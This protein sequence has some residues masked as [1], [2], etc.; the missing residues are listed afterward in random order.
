M[1]KPRQGRHI[2]KMSPL[3][4]ELEDFYARFLQIFRAYGAETC[5]EGISIQPSVFMNE[6]PPRAFKSNDCDIDKVG[7]LRVNCV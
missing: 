7:A 6:I 5:L 1:T 4:T 3:L 2:R